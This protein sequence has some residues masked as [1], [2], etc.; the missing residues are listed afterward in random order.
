MNEVIYLNEDEFEEFVLRSE[1]P[2]L[3]EFSSVLCGPCNAMR[4]VLDDLAAALG[5]SGK[6]V[7]IEITINQ[8]LADEY[9]I[10]G[11]PTFI[12]FKDGQPRNRMVGLQSKAKLL[13]ALAA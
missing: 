13:E 11:V 10:T 7:V 12:D 5:D 1:V 8:R 9:K 3:V 2:V 6:I 4:P